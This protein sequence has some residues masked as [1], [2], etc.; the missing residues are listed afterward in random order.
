MRQLGIAVLR[1]RMA[2]GVGGREL[3]SPAYPIML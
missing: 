2:G 3:K 1:I